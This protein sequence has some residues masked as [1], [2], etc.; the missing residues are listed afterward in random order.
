M[1]SKILVLIFWVIENEVT[2][3]KTHTCKK[4]PDA[5]ATVCGDVSH[6]GDGTVVEEAD[7]KTA[8][9]MELQVYE[10][11]EV[12]DVDYHVSPFNLPAGITDMVCLI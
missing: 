1:V 4:N 5:S 11:K 3:E 8:D 2:Q 7:E 12:N 10:D 6:P 9:N